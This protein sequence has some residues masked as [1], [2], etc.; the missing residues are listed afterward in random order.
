MVNGFISGSNLM[1]KDFRFGIKIL[2]TGKP[3][4]F[5]CPKQNVF[6]FLWNFLPAHVFAARV[7]WDWFKRN[8]NDI[9]SLILQRREEGEKI[10]YT[11]ESI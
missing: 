9:N 1:A 7:N 5:Q 4:S 3:V 8:I 11:L 2:I 10:S 6:P